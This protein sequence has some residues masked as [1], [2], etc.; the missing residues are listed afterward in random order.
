M[1]SRVVAAGPPSGRDAVYPNFPDADLDGWAHAYWGT[2]HARLRQI[3][4][5]YD[6]GNLFWA[7]Q[8]LHT[9]AS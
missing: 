5:R 8:G 9:G 3:K 6:P 4:H 2:N 1:V 7:R